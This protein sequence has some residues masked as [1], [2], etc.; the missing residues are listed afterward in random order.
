MRTSRHSMDFLFAIALFFVFAST[1]LIVLLL[2][3]NIYRHNVQQSSNAFEQNT[4][5]AYITE[6]IRQNDASDTTIHLTTFDG[7][8]ALAISKSYNEIGYTTYIYEMDGLLKEI[9]IQDG[10]PANA[11]A[12]TSILKVSN[13][14]MIELD[15]GLF[16]FTCESAD[17]TQDSV[18]VHVQSMNQ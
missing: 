7:Y 15:H 9:L 3:A 13:L 14:E 12:G 10:V 17:K 11:Q 18:I 2:A 5:L 4:S 6:K 16:R 8:D 1:S